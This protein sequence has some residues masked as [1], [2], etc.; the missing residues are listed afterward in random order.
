MRLKA[1]T[2]SNIA[3]GVAG[4][5]KKYAIIIYVEELGEMRCR[6]PPAGAGNQ[7]AAVWDCRLLPAA[8][9]GPLT[10]L[11]LPGEKP[12]AGSPRD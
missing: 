5:I 7:C 2:C 4:E 8:E 11:H 1:A 12:P 10:G 6:E 3:D 9:D